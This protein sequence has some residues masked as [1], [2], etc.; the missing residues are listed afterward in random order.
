[1]NALTLADPLT[2]PGQPHTATLELP[3]LAELLGRDPALAEM[4]EA[5][6]RCE[7]DVLLR[8]SGPFTLLAFSNADFSGL[9]AWQGLS[10]QQLFADRDRLSQLMLHHLLPGAWARCELPWGA[11]LRSAAGQTLRFSALG[12]LCDELGGQALQQGS[13]HIAS[14]GVLHRLARPLFIA[15]A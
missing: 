2:P 3:T 6:R 14:N 15:V 4:A 11:E 8:C 10:R 12:Q 5:W 13:D 7:L 9:A 1:M